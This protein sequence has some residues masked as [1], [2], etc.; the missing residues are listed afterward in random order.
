MVKG[1]G[2][3]VLHRTIETE[4]V[5]YPEMLFGYEGNENKDLTIVYFVQGLFFLISLGLLI[6]A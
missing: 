5:F 4:P 2:F 1:V 6:M 3:M